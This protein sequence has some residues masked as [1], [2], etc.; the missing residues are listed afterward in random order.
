[1]VAAGHPR[2]R[3]APQVLVHAALDDP[4][5]QLPVRAVLPSPRDA[6]VEPPVG[7]L[8]RARGVVAA[9]VERGA[10][11]ERER[12]VRA[13]RG[14]D[15]HRRLRTHEALGPVDVRPKANALLVDRE[16]AALAVASTALDL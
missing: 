5:E 10:L 16:D 6:A 9:G 3:L 8:G 1:D 15:L 2:G 11:V 12:N 4:E 14:L 7:P 13:Q